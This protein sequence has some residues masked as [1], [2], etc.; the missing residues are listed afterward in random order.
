M[1][2][3]LADTPSARTRLSSQRSNS[4]SSSS[5]RWPTFTPSVVSLMRVGFS[6]LLLW[7]AS[8]VSFAFSTMAA[9]CEAEFLTFAVAGFAL[10]LGALGAGV[11]SDRVGR[12]RTV[13][14]L[15]ATGTVVSGVA[16]VL[17]PSDVTVLLVLTALAGTAA[18]GSHVSAEL[19]LEAVPAQSR[20][21]ALLCFPV[22]FLPAG[23]VQAGL[24]DLG[25]TGSATLTAVLC[26]AAGL[27]LSRGFPEQQQQHAASSSMSRLDRSSS[28]T[29][30]G[31][32]AGGSSSSSSSSS[33]SGGVLLRDSSPI[34]DRRAGL[35]RGGSGQNHS[36]EEEEGHRFVVR[37][38]EDDEESEAAIAAA[39][40]AAAGAGVGGLVASNGGS[41]ARVDE[42]LMTDLSHNNHHQ[43]IVRNGAELLAAEDAE[44][45]RL[46]R[47][48]IFTRLVLVTSLLWILF[49]GVYWLSAS[50][51]EAMAG[52]GGGS[53]GSGVNPE[54]HTVA[55]FCGH[56]E[57][58][59]IAGTAVSKT[60]ELAAGVVSLGGDKGA[61]GCLGSGSASGGSSSSTTLMGSAHLLLAEV[62]AII[63]VAFMSNSPH[64]GRKWTLAT[65]FGSAGV[66][67]AVAGSISYAAPSCS[68]AV[69]V[70]ALFLEFLLRAAI[71]SAGQALFL[72]TLEATATTQRS[73]AAGIALGAFRLGALL[74][75][76]GDS[77]AAPSGRLQWSI[78][79]LRTEAS[80][81]GF[82]RGSAGH[83]TAITAALAAC[84]QA[85]IVAAGL[86]ACLPIDTA[87][88]QLRVG[89]YDAFTD[90][91]GQEE[92][93]Y[94]TASPSPRNSNS[95]DI[96][97]GGGGGEPSQ[98]YFC[99]VIAGR[100]MGT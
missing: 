37:S 56:S 62:V 19:F 88:K 44:H 54:V 7:L 31:G 43:N 59:S 24:R 14:I 40:G 27:V 95:D 50:A 100:L 38:Q 89:A 48:P 17:A 73:T 28:L 99:S 21:L 32:G 67:S 74:S 10:A 29:R 52:G 11:F 9:Q 76:T 81:F 41:S 1:L 39:V 60:A 77:S 12:L 34:R 86:C 26:A 83:T 69:G 15:F 64:F 97:N 63:C 20:A 53:G 5:S 13:R 93:L 70:G 94:T 23:A 49:I 90:V 3:Y 79:A 98:P 87:L 85:C 16:A 61:N 51:L 66:L 2:L 91:E 75:L 33:S 84:A 65:T 68:E 71:V 46:V 25:W 45:L 58:L 30:V 22:L 82:A 96:I 92:H 36:M 8:L 4:P 78:Y 55:A 47:S 18:G 42:S 57:P 35:S 80:F 72:Y 6:T